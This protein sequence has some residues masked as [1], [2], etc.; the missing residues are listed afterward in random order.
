MNVLINIAPR[1][2][3]IGFIYKGRQTEGSRAGVTYREEGRATSGAVSK[4]KD[5]HA[6]CKTKKGKNR[7]L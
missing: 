6:A 3:L 1:H 5:A 7:L 2:L 4:K